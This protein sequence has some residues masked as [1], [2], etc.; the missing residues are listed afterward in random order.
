MKG[1]V[2]VGDIGARSGGRRTAAGLGAGTGRGLGP[3]S[4]RLVGRRFALPQPLFAITS[5][6]RGAMD[7]RRHRGGALITVWRRNLPGAAAS[8]TESPSG[9]FEHCFRVFLSTRRCTATCEPTNRNC[10]DGASHWFIPSIVRMVA[11]SLSSASA[12][13]GSTLGRPGRAGRSGGLLAN[14]DSW[15]AIGGKIARLPTK[16]HARDWSP[17]S[18]SS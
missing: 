15:E 1:G 6:L 18:N 9:A 2:G 4:L 14:L 11:H 12:G 13:G 8:P 3:E 5:S 16:S 17:N 10:F 7:I